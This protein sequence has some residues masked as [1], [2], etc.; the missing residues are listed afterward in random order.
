MRADDMVLFEVSIAG[1]SIGQEGF[2]AMELPSLTSL[3]HVGAL[4]LSW[5][6]VIVDLV[7]VLG[8]D[9]SYL[10]SFTVSS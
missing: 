2:G 6:M 9:C 10:S 1:C 7:S 4:V 5:W 8:F 3:H